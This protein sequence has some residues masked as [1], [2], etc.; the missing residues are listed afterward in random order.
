LHVLV[1]KV[2]TKSD[3]K[4]PLEYQEEALEHVIHVQEGSSPTLFGP[5]GFDNKDDNFLIFRPA[6]CLWCFYVFYRFLI[7][8]ELPIMYENINY[9]L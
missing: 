6:L 5:W 2:S 3:L 9:F 1:L 8:F 4:G 7:S